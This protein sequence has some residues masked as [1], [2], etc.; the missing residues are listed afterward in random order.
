M[1]ALLASANPGKLRELRRALPGWEIEPLEADDYPPESGET[2]Y[3]N[4]RAKDR[5]GREREPALWVLGEDSG[6]EVA[7]LDGAPGIKSARFAGGMHVE[8]LLSELG[9][10]EGE[11]RGARYVCVNTMGAGLATPSEHV[12]ALDRVMAALGQDGAR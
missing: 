9:R 7:G 4:A 5:F 10:V 12:A 2:Y 6:L 8:R 11:G 1:N 3:E